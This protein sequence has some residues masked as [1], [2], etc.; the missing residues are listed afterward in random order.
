MKL[1]VEWRQ[2]LKR[3]WS[4]RLMVLAALLSGAEV[5]LPFLGDLLEPGIL[6]ALSALATAGAFAARILAQKDMEN[7]T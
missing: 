3:A 2:V 7:G 1:I 4:V 5:A 6:A